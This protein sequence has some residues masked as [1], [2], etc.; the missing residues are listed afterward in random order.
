MILGR[1]GFQQ[2]VRKHHQSDETY[3]CS[4]CSKEFPTCIVLYKHRKMCSSTLKRTIPCDKCNMKF[5]SVGRLRVHKTTNH[6]K[7]GENASRPIHESIRFVSQFHI[8]KKFI[9]LYLLSKL[10]QSGRSCVPCF[11]LGS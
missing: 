10:L 11:W 3:P 8:H 6:Y 9:K 1:A 2:H 5:S 7:G 4:K